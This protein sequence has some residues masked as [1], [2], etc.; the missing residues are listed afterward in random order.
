ML[1]RQRPFHPTAKV[2]DKTNPCL[3][4]GDGRVNQRDIYVMSNEGDA[5]AISNQRDGRLNQR[6]INMM[7]NPRDGDMI[8]SQRDRRLNQSDFNV[9]PSQHC[10]KLNQRDFYGTQ[11]PYDAGTVTRSNPSGSQRRIKVAKFD[12]TE[13][14]GTFMAKFNNAENYNGWSEGSNSTN[15]KYVEPEQRPMCCGIL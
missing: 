15:E 7:P 2:R 4:E 10:V 14:F 6:D 12:G 8:S 1:R 5:N 9:M 3:S 11:A 13:T